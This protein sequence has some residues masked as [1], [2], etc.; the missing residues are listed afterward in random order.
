M[1]WNTGDHRTTS[2]SRLMTFPG[3]AIVLPKL[4]NSTALKLQ[5]KALL[6]QIRCCGMRDRLQEV[7]WS[8]IDEEASSMCRKLHGAI[9][10][11]SQIRSISLSSGL[12]AWIVLSRRHSKISP[13]PAEYEWRLRRRSSKP[14][15]TSR[16]N[17]VLVAC[18]WDVWPRLAARSR[19]SL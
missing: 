7:T 19:K 4:S 18:A 13:T 17:G 1:L 2:S 9:W 8:G 10:A 3:A 6:E 14:G 15:G 11:K 12:W 5:L 16:C